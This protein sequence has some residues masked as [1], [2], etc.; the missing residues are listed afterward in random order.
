MP[1]YKNFRVNIYE[2]SIVDGNTPFIDALT[3]A[4]ALPVIQRER[5][6]SGR[7]RRIDE[8]DQRLEEFLVNFTAFQF[9]GPG[10]VT[11]GG[12][13]NPMGLDAD[14]FYSHDTA[15]LYDLSTNLV[16]LESNQGGMGATAVKEYLQEFVN[17]KTV[18]QLIHQTDDNAAARARLFQTIRKMRVRLNLGPPTD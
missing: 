10:R 6:I 7:R 18:Y 16:F 2:A 1:E 4:C 13:S 8:Y 15:M 14:E 11:I 17:D 9:P 3:T 12:A 5:M